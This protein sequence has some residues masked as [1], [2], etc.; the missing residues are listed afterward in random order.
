LAARERE[1]IGRAV[2]DGATPRFVADYN[3]GVAAGAGCGA[4]DAG[5]AVAC[6]GGAAADYCYD[7]YC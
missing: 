1:G 4:W 5:R 7:Q 6:A 3:A 2:D